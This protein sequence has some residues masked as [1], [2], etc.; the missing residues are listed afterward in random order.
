MFPKKM[1]NLSSDAESAIFTLKIGKSFDCLNNSRF[2]FSLFNLKTSFGCR[3]TLGQRG[4]DNTS[5]IK[6]LSH[7]PTFLMNSDLVLFQ[8]DPIKP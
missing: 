7:R 1:W 4:A 8:F 3:N 6:C 5:R 2:V